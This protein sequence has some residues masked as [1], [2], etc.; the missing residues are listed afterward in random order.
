MHFG[1]RLVAKRRSQSL[2]RTFGSHAPSALAPPPHDHETMHD[3]PAAAGAGA[4]C[5]RGSSA[6]SMA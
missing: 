1:Y 5:E 4:A 3:Q 6:W 2:V